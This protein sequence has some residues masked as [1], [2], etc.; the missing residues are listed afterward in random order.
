MLAQVAR[1]A[2]DDGTTASVVAALGSTRQPVKID[3]ARIDRQIREV[4]L[5]HA[6]GGLGDDAYLT[7]L[8]VLREARD[9]IAEGSD[10]GVSAQRA[11]EWLRALA[12]SLQ[13][14]DVAKEKEDLMH[15]IYERITMAGPRIVGIRLSSAA[16]VHGLA[17]ALPQERLQWRA[18]QVSHAR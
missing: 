17:L 4:A 5:E 14:A 18:R 1:V 16:Y 3:R 10:I 15:A 9:A 8:T 11:I 12:E 6:A 7:R 2:L 13:H